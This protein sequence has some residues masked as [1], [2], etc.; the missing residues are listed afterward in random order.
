MERKPRFS[1]KEHR[2]AE[3]IIESEEERGY[4][5]EEAERIGYATIN[6]HRDEEV[7]EE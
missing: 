7:D 6:K 1:D 3:H 5:P 2:E 4:S